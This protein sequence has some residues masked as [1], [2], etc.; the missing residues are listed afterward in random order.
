LSFKGD[1]KAWPW[2]GVVEEVVGVCFWGNGDR[3]VE[4]PFLKQMD[5]GQ[6]GREGKVEEALDIQARRTVD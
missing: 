1:G 2:L 4:K 3:L 6:A 5:E